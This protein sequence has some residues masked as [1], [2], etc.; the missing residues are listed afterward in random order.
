MVMI[1]VDVLG[2]INMIEAGL[3]SIIAATKRNKNI[4]LGI[5]NKR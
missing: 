2:D 3:P 1:L 4:P 5:L